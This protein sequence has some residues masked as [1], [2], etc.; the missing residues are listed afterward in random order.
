MI[1][2]NSCDSVLYV[3]KADST[4]DKVIKSGLARFI[5]VGHRVDGVILNQVNLKKSDVA[6]R[7]GGFYDEYGYTSHKS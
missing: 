5:Q 1:V 6:Q 2:A 3:V 7:Y 4:S